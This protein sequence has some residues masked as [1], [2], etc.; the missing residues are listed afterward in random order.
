MDLTQIINDS[1]N[2]VVTNAEDTEIQVSC[3][4]QADLG[5]IKADERRLRQILFNLMTNALRFTESGGSITITATKQDEMIWLSVADTGK[6]IEYEQ[7]ASV[8]DSFNSGDR[9]GAGLGLALVR[10]FVELHGG[11][12]LMQSAPGKG[13]KVICMLPVDSS[14]AQPSDGSDAAFKSA[15]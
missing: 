11:Q 7:Q 14:T 4:L 6:G 9:Q 5:M 13:T 12:V 8:F 1:V 15:A 2:L 3:D 10:S